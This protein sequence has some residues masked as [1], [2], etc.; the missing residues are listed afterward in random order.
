MLGNLSG[1]MPQHSLAANKACVKSWW[2]SLSR[3][4]QT[5]SMRV[6]IETVSE[7]SAGQTV[8]DVWH[9]SNKPKNVHVAQ[10]RQ[11]TL[12]LGNT[13]FHACLFLSSVAG[14]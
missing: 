2:N 4:V 13:A 9:Q 1:V 14:N 6:D 12:L 11:H 10:V 5:E 7:L 3:V 8:C